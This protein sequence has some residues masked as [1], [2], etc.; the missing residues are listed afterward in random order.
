M[1]YEDLLTEMIICESSCESFLACESSVRDLNVLLVW[2][3]PFT[4]LGTCSYE[5]LAKKPKQQ[6]LYLKE[7]KN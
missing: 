6:P 2:P 4:V 3:A 1:R 5:F 7:K